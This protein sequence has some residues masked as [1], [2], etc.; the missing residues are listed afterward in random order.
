MPRREITRKAALETHDAQVPLGRSCEDR[1]IM[2]YEG[3]H[4]DKV[5]ART[6]ESMLLPLSTSHWGSSF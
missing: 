5:N 3:D 4:K 6:K 1:P 2:V